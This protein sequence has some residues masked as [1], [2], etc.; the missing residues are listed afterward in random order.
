MADISQVREHME[1]IGADGVHVGTVDKVEG[2][3]IKLTRKDSGS[4]SDHHH[5]IS[6]GLIATIEGDRIRLSANGDAAVLLEEEEGGE[7]ITDKRLWNWNK[8]GVGAA[9]ALGVAAA[10]AG[11]AKLVQQQQQQR[12]PDRRRFPDAARDGR[13]C[14]PHLLDQG[15]GTPVVGTDGETLG[16][17]QSFMVDKYTGR[18]AYAVMKFGGTMGVGTSLFPLPWPILEYDVEKDGYALDISKE[19]MANAPR[20]EPNKE[21]EFSPEYRRT[22]ISF[23]RPA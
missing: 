9:A 13:E 21:P 7:A 15:R 14:P 17:I 1:V 19:Q 6:Q 22:L 11:A 8:I 10:A 4:H 5:Y 3:R 20:F 23:Y 16:T 18:V 12:R 2:K